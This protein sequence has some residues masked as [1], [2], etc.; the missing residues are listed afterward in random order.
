MYSSVML[1]AHGWERVAGP[2]LVGESGCSAG[3]EEGVRASLGP[4]SRSS[5]PGVLILSH[6][7]RGQLVA[8]FCESSLLG[9]HPLT[10]W[11]ATEVLVLGIQRGEGGVCPQRAC[12]LGGEVRVVWMHTHRWGS[13]TVTL[14]VSAYRVGGDSPEQGAAGGFE[15]G[16]SMDPNAHQGCWLPVMKRKGGK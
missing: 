13:E 4:Y 7:Q 16:L 10:V 15:K 5:R 3:A 8:E 6:R 2:S 11:E 9:S 1:P 12:S 14:L